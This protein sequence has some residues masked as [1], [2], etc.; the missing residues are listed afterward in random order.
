MGPFS[1]TD[2]TSLAAES[3]SDISVTLIVETIDGIISHP[4]NKPFKTYP[5]SPPINLASSLHAASGLRT[6]SR[7]LTMKL[8][9]PT[10]ST[11]G[12]VN[13]SV[14]FIV[15]IPVGGIVGGFLGLLLPP[16]P[17][18]IDIIR[19]RNTRENI[20]FIFMALMKPSS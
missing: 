3:N 1:V 12:D 6:E 19:L 4:V 7:S 18:I 5:T 20:I 14:G 16:C 11:G 13:V 15:G 8:L 9:L 10:S 17:S 2:S